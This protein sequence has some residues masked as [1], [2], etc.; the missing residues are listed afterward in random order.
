MVAY[1]IMASGYTMLAFITDYVLFYMAF[2]W[3]AIGAAL[4]KPV[5]TAT[6]AKTTDEKT[7][8]VGFG[9]F[10]MMVNL[11]AFIGPIVA[12]KLRIFSWQYIF[13]ISA[14]VTVINLI[15]VA[16]LYREPQREKDNRPLG[17]SMKTIFK[18]IW[19]AVKDVRFLLFLVI[20]MGFWAMYNQ[21]FYTLPVFIQQWMDTS[22][23]YNF[24]YNISP[25]LANAIGTR[26]G[27]VEPEIITNLDAMYIV[28]FQV[29]VSTLVMRF[30][31]LT[32]MTSGIIVAT[33]GL[34]LSFATNNPFFLVFS[35]FIFAV[36]EMSS[37]PK[38]NEYIGRIAPKDKVALYM[39]ASFIPVAGG[40]LLAGFI[41]GDLYGRMSDKVNLLIHD[42]TSKGVEVP[43]W[44]R[45]L[46]KVT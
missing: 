38:I 16:F 33:I 20:I 7:S 2:I 43:H 17:E 30:R 15:L 46:P 23:L 41:S 10:Y 40:N 5:I 36:G 9:I 12:S 24:L 42:L 22:L 11:G 26:E 35:L 3:L 45:N 4:F 13:F 18:N 39:G 14:A 32:A 28:I 25:G 19:L 6:I 44:M 29:L 34:S 27:I 37:S 21:L 8:S 1:A 31:P